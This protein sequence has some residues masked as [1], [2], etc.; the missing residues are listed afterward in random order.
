MSSIDFELVLWGFGELRSEEPVRP[1]GR[2]R[3]VISHGHTSPAAYAALAHLGWFDRSLPLARVPARRLAV[4]G[5]RREGRARGSTGARA[6]SGRDSRPPSGFALA[7]RIKGDGAKVFCAMGD[8]E[9]QKGQLGE[10]RRFAVKYG[11]TNLVGVLDWNR[12]QLS[13]S[14]DDD[15]QAGHRGGLEGRRL[16]R[17]SR[18]TATTSA[19]SIAPSARRSRAASPDARRLRT[20]S[21][22]RASRSWR[23]TGY[24]WHGAALAPDRCK[25]ALAILGAPDDLDHWIDERKKTAPDWHAVLPHRPVETVVLPSRGNAARRTRS[26]RS[27]DNRGAF[28]DALEDLGALSAARSGRAASRWRSSTATS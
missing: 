13:G 19:P 4:R 17:R 2:D 28:G 15:P 26:T 7:A 16:G 14:N 5:T 10:A 8:G 11:L 23:R 1:D 20:R 18:S 9:Q 27:T 3:V 24:K 6:T 12:D 25:E 21:C 22:R